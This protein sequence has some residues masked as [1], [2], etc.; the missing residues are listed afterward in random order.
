[1]RIGSVTGNSEQRSQGKETTL[2]SVITYQM[3]STEKRQI[4]WHEEKNICHND[5][6]KPAHKERQHEN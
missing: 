4:I 5:K 1:M 3:T 6:K 2:R